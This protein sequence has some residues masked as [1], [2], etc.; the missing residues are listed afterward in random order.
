M[1]KNTK[2]TNNDI[3]IEDSLKKLKDL[4]EKDLI[5]ES[6]YQQK[7]KELLDML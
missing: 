3:D 1:K 6:E 4:K 7:K 5:D 2:P